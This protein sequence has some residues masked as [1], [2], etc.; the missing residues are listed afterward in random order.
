MAMRE[1]G[2]AATHRGRTAFT[3]R[4]GIRPR[5]PTA[6]LRVAGEF[7]GLSRA[8]QG[9]LDGVFLPSRFDATEDEPMLRGVYFT[10]AAQAETDI[11]ADSRTLLQ[12]LR[13]AMRRSRDRA[14]AE[15]EQPDSGAVL[16]A[17][18]TRAH[19]GYFLHDL[20]LKVI[21]AEAHL[22]RPNLRWEVRFRLLRLLGHAL[23]IAIFAALAAALASSFHHNRDYLRDVAQRLDR[24][25]GQLD[26]LH[27]DGPPSGVPDVLAAARALPVHPL[28]DVSHPD[29]APASFSYGLYSAAPVME[30]AARTY[31][32]LQEYTMLPPIL[33]RMEDVMGRSV[34]EGDARAAYETLRV[35]R[36]LHDA[37]R[38]ARPGSARA[39]RDWVVG[40][41]ERGDGTAS[42]GGRAAMRAHVDTL[43]SGERVVGAASRPNEAL[44]REVQRLLDGRTTT[45]RLYER[46]RSALRPEA[47]QDFTLLRAVGLQAGTVFSRA[48]GRSL[49]E[50]VPGLYTHDGYHALFAPRLADFVRSALDD[51]AWVMGR[52]DAAREQV[53]V[54]AAIEDVRRQYL[55]DYA[56]QWEE[57]LASIRPVG[58]GAAMPAE[59]RRDASTTAPA[60]RDG[61]S[62]RDAAPLEALSTGL[63]TGLGVD[64]GVLRQFAAPDSA[65]TRL[66]RAAVRETTLVVPA[67]Q[68]EAATAAVQRSLLERATDAL[69]KAPDATAAGRRVPDADEARTLVRLVDSRFAAL[70]EVVTGSPD[71]NAPM[72]AASV[73][74]ARL[75]LEA[76]TGIVNEFYTV[77]AVADNALA[78]GSLPS[79][80]QEVGARLRLEAGKLPAP[81]R[82]VLLGL[83]ASGNAKVT[84][85]TAGIL[86]RQAQEQLDRL[87]GLLAVQVG[88]PCRRG[89]EGRYPMAP[90]PHDASSDDF[91]R[92]FASG[93]AF[94]EFFNR[95]LAPF[96]D[97]GSRPWR[98]RNPDSAWR[99]PPPPGADPSGDGAL[100]RTGPPEPTL[101]GELL[102]LLARQGP[103]LDAFDRARQIRDVFFGEAGGRKL[104]WKLDLKVIELDPSITD[105]VIDIDGQGQRYAHGPVQALNL[106]WP[107]PRGG[108]MAELTA[109][110][111]VSGP[112]SGM[113]TSGPWALLR[114]LERGRVV[115]TAL[116][117]RVNV[118]YLFDGRRA[119]IE[120]GT[121]S[122]AGLLG[123]DLLRGFRC[124][125]RA[126]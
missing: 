93:G 39:V 28:L 76:V 31:A 38:Y 12:R 101:P 17:A 51:D 20:F 83:A 91:T 102:R 30:A 87:A 79:S 15:A 5:S 50:G 94:D 97:T 13:R 52:S 6:P 63:S 36:L 53:A 11:P 71:A 48:S 126:A 58:Q 55:N 98:Y 66:A 96:V 99:E 119:L 89:I 80:G 105:L 116:A 10:S 2:V 95:H 65:L 124:P 29:S 19:R 18:P 4:R 72:A 3:T 104:G 70:R 68:A 64:L 78:A 69:G 111:R 43:F 34:R 33:L 60:G 8:L 121:S 62:M 92:L 81:L 49:D 115:N 35:Y 84:R 73:S 120:I 100:P 109:N 123:G 112:T 27:A 25:S 47:P 21:V 85:G 82:E 107:G 77:L 56:R 67:T 41:W 37:A 22:V 61:L 117:G 46:A 44:V 122:Q 16:D 86:R 23:A 57:F 106:T 108:A 125:G 9:V 40:D 103:D 54:D 26:A 90:G 118:E 14:G 114:L 59:G 110:P 24:L 113:L 74:A 1:R 75:G 32:R 42:F 7:A 45:E 88:E